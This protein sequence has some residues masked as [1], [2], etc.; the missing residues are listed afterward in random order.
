M[1]EEEY[2]IEKRGMED[3]IGREDGIGME[4]EDRCIP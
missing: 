1:N 4:E 2:K 3:V